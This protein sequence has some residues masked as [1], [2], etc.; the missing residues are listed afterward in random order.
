M[1]ET[2][3]TKRKG[4]TMASIRITIETDGTAFHELDGKPLSRDLHPFVE[5]VVVGGEVARI[6]RVM[7]IDAERAGVDAMFDPRDLNGNACS[8]VEVIN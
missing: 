5:R 6:L 3:A 8:K 7:A 2:K 1:D 4:E